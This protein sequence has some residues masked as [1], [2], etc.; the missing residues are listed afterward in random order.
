MLVLQEVFVLAASVHQ[1][2]LL[3]RQIVAIVEDVGLHDVVDD[4][5]QRLT[6]VVHVEVLG[7]E[8]LGGLLQPEGS[9]L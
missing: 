4:G 9:G 3:P 5:R 7:A 8:S 2:L 1:L 6:A